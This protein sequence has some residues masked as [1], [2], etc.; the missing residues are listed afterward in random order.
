MTTPFRETVPDSVTIA[1]ALG[2]KAGIANAETFSGYAV[3]V[4]NVN[5]TR[6]IQEAR[7]RAGFA[8]TGSSGKIDLSA[9]GN[10]RGTLANPAGSGR[11][12]YLYTISTF[13]TAQ[14]GFAHTYINPTAG[15]PTVLKS[16]NNNFIG[17]PRAAVGVVRV[18]VDALTALS[19]GTDTGLAIGIASNERAEIELA[20]FIIPPGV[21]MGI[22]IPFAGATSVTFNLN[23]WEE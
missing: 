13:S 16:S 21:T 20:P 7:V 11:T 1:D 3:A 5:P 15:L 2:N 17:H 8:F 19:G 10:L 4:R 6:Q 18:D 9:A 22:N 14:G 12:I 23:W